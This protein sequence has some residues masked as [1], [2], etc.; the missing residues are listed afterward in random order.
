MSPTA[1]LESSG[2]TQSRLKYPLKGIIPPLVTPLLDEDTLDVQGLERLIEHV[3]QGG[4]H[5]IF[6]LG[7]TGE[8]P[9]LS[10]Q[11]RQQTIE[12]SA[13][14]VA[15]RVPLLVGITDTSLQESLSLA[16]CAHKH[17]ADAVVLAPPYYFPAGQTEL[18]NWLKMIVPRLPL[19]CFLYNLPKITKLNF[20]LPTIKEAM[21]MSNCIGLKDSSGN[22]QYVHSIL[23]DVKRSHPEFSVLIGPEDLIADGVLFG[24]DGAVPGGANV[25]PKLFVDLY[26]AADAGDIA[27]VRGLQDQVLLQRQTLYSIGKYESKAI[28]ALK[29]ALSIL[30]ICSDLLAPPFNKFLDEERQ[31]V[32]DGLLLLEDNGIQFVEEPLRKRQKRSPS[33]DADDNADDNDDDGHVAHNNPSTPQPARDPLLLK[34]DAL[35]KTPKDPLLL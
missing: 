14:I 27:Q 9:H 28:K 6:V 35:L 15:G 24:A 25:S 1:K 17:N 33:P 4:V 20:D 32:E 18:L 3:L 34:T 13:K 21:K 19:P 16:K 31:K 22:M 7:T 12:H 30:G 10:Y 11:L 2:Q 5:G 26:S 23:K 8:T 29:S